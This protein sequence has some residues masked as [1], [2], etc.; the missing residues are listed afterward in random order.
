MIEIMAETTA[1]KVC[2]TV[3]RDV[4]TFKGIPYGAPTG[5]ER[6]F[7][8]PL[9][10]KPWSRPRF[11]GDYGPICPQTG[12]LVD[13]ARPYALSRAEG[14]QRFLPQ[15]ENCLVLNVW[16]K[17]V[18]DGGKR[19]VL[20]W[21]HGRGFAEGAGSET[22][23]N[24]ANLARRGD[25]V[26]ITINH[27]LNVFGF[28]YLEQLAG[29]TFKGSGTAGMLDAELALKWVRDNAENFGGNPG[30]V[31]IFGESGGSR[32]VS[33]LMAM[34][35]AQ[36]LFQKAIIQSSPGLRGRT[37]GAATEFAERLLAKLGIKAD[38]I[39]KLQQLPAQKLLDAVTNL[40]PES[41]RTG[42][43]RARDIMQL[44]PVVDGHFLPA[45]PFDPIAAPTAAD[46]PL[47]IGTNRDENALFLARDPRRRKLTETE[48][49]ERLKPELGD[50][51]DRILNTYRKTR[52]GATP[53]DLLVGI[54][55]E[56]R[57]IGCRKLIEAKLAAGQAP[58]YNYLFTYESDFLGGLLKAG[59]AIEIPFVFDNADD[60]PMVGD[61]PDK[62]EMAAAMSKAWIA[63]AKKGDPNHQGIPDWKPYTLENRETMILDVPCRLENDPA[64]E[65]L[66]AWEGMEVIP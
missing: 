61:R 64:R 37:P 66:D 7:L 45:N 16:T 28:L 60:V 47:I 63:F 13:E 57:R 24:G 34:P 32:K 30:N 22:M 41:R 46:I 4:Y 18:N 51:M 21:L 19:P 29:E 17:A 44:S 36:G 54:T 48:L 33:I 56:A 20:V 5:G 49:I 39:Q 35:S 65:E 55:S 43:R 27:R 9:P 6:R 11:A 10:V 2:G 59:H 26:V 12:S 31:T 40:T 50:Y 1:G 8:P 23:Y 42:G 62:A 3:E 53:W 14:F 25:V 15:S 52:P 58:V 38:E